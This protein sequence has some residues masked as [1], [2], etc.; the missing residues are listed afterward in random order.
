[1]DHH[2]SL[3]D[4]L[5]SLLDDVDKQY[6]KARSAEVFK[7]KRHKKYSLRDDQILS[8]L[9]E[10]QYDTNQELEHIITLI[11]HILQNYVTGLRTYSTDDAD[12]DNE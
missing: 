2:P 7:Q 8:A 3:S 12:S 1:M 11:G 4:F 9:A 6:D 5:Q 10:A